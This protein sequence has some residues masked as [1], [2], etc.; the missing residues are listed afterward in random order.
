MELIP[1]NQF[2]KLRLKQFVGSDVEVTEGDGWEWMG[3]H[4]INEGISSFTSFS[5]LKDTPEETGGLEIDLDELPASSARAILGAIQLPLRSGMKLEEVYAVLGEPTKKDA[6]GKHVHDRQTDEF[7]VG[8]KE[9][10]YVS[11]TVHNDSGLIYLTVI[12]K[13]VLSRIQAEEAAFL[14]ELKA[15]EAAMESAIQAE[16]EAKWGEK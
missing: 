2:A 10:Y 14:A 9:A 15:E 8:S 7:E 16:V 5:R 11:S 12:R 6:F 3:G 13:D 4:W 1:Y